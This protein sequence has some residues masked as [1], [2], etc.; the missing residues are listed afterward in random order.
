MSDSSFDEIYQIKQEGDAYFLYEWENGVFE[1]EGPDSDET[2][3][4]IGEFDFEL[5]E[6]YPGYV[7]IKRYAPTP[8]T[9]DSPDY[10]YEVEEKTIADFSQSDDLVIGSPDFSD[11][12]PDDII[13]NFNRKINRL[14]IDLSDFP[15]AKPSIKRCKTSAKLDKALTKEVGFV[16][17]SQAGVLFFNENGSE[18]GFGAGGA[19]L[20]FEGDYSFKASCVDFV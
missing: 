7:E 15:G 8:S 20:K 9:T 2:L 6:S 11:D 3:T 19:F 5:K 12:I 17:D 13:N 18:N 10:Y 4:Q 1:K 14:S 16:F